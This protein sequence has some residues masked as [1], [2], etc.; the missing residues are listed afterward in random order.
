MFVQSTEY[1]EAGRVLSYKNY[2]D[3]IIIVPY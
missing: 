2:S 3:L 1:T